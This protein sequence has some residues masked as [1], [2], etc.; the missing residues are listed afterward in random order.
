MARME[1]LVDG[2]PAFTIAVPST[3]GYETFAEVEAPEHPL[4]AAGTHNLTV[5]FPV[6]SMNLDRL[7]LS[8]DQP[9]P[10][11]GGD[12]PLDADGDGLYD[13]ANGNGRMDFADVVLFFNQMTW[14]AANEPVPAFDCNG[15][16]R[17][18]F[19][20]R[21][22]ALQSPLSREEPLFFLIPGGR[23]DSDRW[24]RRGPPPTDSAWGRRVDLPGPCRFCSVNRRSRPFVVRWGAREDCRSVILPRIPPNLFIPD[25]RWGGV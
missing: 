11:P 22:L 24:R 12:T 6:G 21:R 2:A 1:V 9:A 16:G 23:V 18:D 17:I 3:G 8:A 19:C 5:R 25:R 13:D 7:T 10:F 4:L 20:R 15:N 14:I